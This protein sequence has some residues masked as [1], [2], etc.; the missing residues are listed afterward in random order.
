ATWPISVY[1]GAR[2]L[3]WDRWT[4]G[5]AAAV[6]PLIVS[7]PGYGFEHASYVW[8]GYGVYS[9]LWAMWLMPLALGVSWRAVA[10]GRLYA[11]AALA[12]ALTIACHFIAGYLV[13]LTIGVWVVVVWRGF[14]LR[15]GRGALVAGG[16]LL[17][18]AWTLVPLIADTKWSNQSEYYKG[19]FFNDSY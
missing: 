15:V 2:L 12:V 16:A 19:T 3:E 7:T 10:R 8:Q 18:A 4:A 9:Q 17:I 11:V 13:L 6:S 1:M 14:W 5:S